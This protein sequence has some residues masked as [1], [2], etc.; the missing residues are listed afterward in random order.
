MRPFQCR[1]WALRTRLCRSV[2]GNGVK[3]RRTEH[4][5]PAYLSFQSTSVTILYSNFFL[6]VCVCVVVVQL[7]RN[8][9]YLLLM[10]CFG[11]AVAIFTCFSTLLEQILCV[12]EYTNVRADTHTHTHTHTHT[13]THTH[14]HTHTHRHRHRHTHTHR[15]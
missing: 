10:I 2:L 7:L 14:T 15:H 6:C 1:S 5:K 12:K 9:A 3:N 8:R 11:S 4:I 13:Q